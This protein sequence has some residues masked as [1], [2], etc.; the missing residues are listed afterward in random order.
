M[1]I[2]LVLDSHENFK[3]LKVLFVSSASVFLKAEIAAVSN[4]SKWFS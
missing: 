3:C 1:K 2:I 4:T